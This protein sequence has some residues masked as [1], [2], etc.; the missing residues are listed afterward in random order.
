MEHVNDVVYSLQYL[1]SAKGKRYKRTSLKER[2][3]NLIQENR[4]I[5]IILASMTFLIAIDI[6]LI[7]SFMNLIIKL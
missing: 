1:S 7:N 3:S 6:L 2:I 4:A 5:T